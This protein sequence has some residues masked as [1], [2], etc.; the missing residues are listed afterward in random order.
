MKLSVF[1]DEINREKPLCA[2]QLARDWGS[3]HVEIRSLPGGRF[4]RLSDGDLEEYRL[5]KWSIW[6]AA[7]PISPRRTVAA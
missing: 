5:Q 4:P 1:A 6:S 2:L 7:W 3:T